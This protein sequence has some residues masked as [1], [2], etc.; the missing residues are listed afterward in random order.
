MILFQ[1]HSIR[2]LNAC[3]LFYIWSLLFIRIRV[4]VYRIWTLLLINRENARECEMNF[5]FNLS[6]SSSSLSTLS[7]L[8]MSSTPYFQH[9]DRCRSRCRWWYTI[10]FLR[11]LFATSGLQFQSI[12]TNDKC[13][14]ASSRRL[15]VCSIRSPLKINNKRKRRVVHSCLAVFTIWDS[16]RSNAYV[17]VVVIWR[18]TAI[19][20]TTYY[21]DPVRFLLTSFN[22]HVC[23]LTNA[24]VCVSVACVDL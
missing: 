13:V 10:L 6:S 3:A 24:Y 2:S 22:S 18:V 7:A 15:F 21:I 5:A 20:A 14:C 9:R 12:W 19:I 1:H 16:L 17:D 4:R 11:F 23:V 8:S